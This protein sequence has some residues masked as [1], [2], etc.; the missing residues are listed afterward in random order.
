MAGAFHSRLME[1]AYQTLSAALAET[2]MNSL[3]V[4]VVCNV[5]AGLLG[6]IR[7]GA[8]VISI[9]NSASLDEVIA[10]LSAS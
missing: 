1:P 9:S 7:K 6:R 5:L 8:P 4:T 2:P 10:A 3:R